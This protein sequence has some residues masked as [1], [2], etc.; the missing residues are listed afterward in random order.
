MR[1][2]LTLLVCVSWL[3]GDGGDVDR[4]LWYGLQAFSA[5]RLVSMVA[6]LE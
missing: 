6:A 1:Q 5:S 2:D 4:W 3:C